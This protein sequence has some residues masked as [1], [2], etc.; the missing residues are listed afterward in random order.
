MEPIAAPRCL[1]AELHLRPDALIKPPSFTQ[2]LERG[3]VTKSTGI[4]VAVEFID[5]NL[6]GA[7]GW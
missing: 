2:S 3:S 7:V 5:S 1:T 4:E 6:D